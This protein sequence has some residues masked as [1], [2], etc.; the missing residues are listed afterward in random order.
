MTDLTD[1]LALYDRWGSERYDE[2]VAQLDNALQTAAHAKLDQIIIKKTLSSQANA[3]ES[4]RAHCA[5][6]FCIN[7]SRVRFRGDF[8]CCVRVRMHLQNCMQ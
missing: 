5:K 3:V 6:F 1:V 4:H 8:G 2:E 7:C